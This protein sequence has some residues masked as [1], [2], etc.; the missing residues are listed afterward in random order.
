MHHWSQP[1]D[2]GYAVSPLLL[3]NTHTQMMQLDQRK[4]SV[5]TLRKVMNLLFA[6][7]ITEYLEIPRELTEKLKSCKEI[8]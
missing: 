1:Q 6:D 8:Q 4:K 5:M 3:I 7:G 2:K